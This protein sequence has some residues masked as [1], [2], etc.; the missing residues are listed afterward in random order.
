MPENIPKHKARP[1][2]GRS[3]ESHKPRKSGATNGPRAS[4]RKRGYSKQWD[5]FS[6]GFLTRNPLCE[7]CLAQG[8]SMPAKVTDHDIP[9]K[10]DPVLFW[11]N[12][13]TALCARCH[14]STKQKMELKFS[15][16]ELLKEIQAVKAGAEPR[17]SGQRR[18]WIEHVANSGSTLVYGPPAGGKSTWANR[19]SKE[20]GAIVYD[21]DD[22]AE[23]IGIP[24][25]QRTKHQAQRALRELMRRL[26]K[27]PADAK[28][29]FVTTAPT[30]KRRSFWAKLL[31]AD[32]VR[33][34]MAP[35]AECKRRVDADPQRRQ[36][37]SHQYEIIERW[38]RTVG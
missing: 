13:F 17:V 9:H 8:R 27:H 5:K 29:I 28:L 21:L 7:F 31:L 1:R 20:T 4:F 38:F 26:G 12:S 36:H 22:I 35:E 14:N 6:K 3:A 15:G 33:L 19:Q 25:Y 32:T 23:E 10:G 37:K 30:P 16:E 34:I 2:I 24:R 11:Q 18:E